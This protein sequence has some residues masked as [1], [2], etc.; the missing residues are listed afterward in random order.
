G[1]LEKLV[2]SLGRALPARDVRLPRSLIHG[3]FKIAQLLVR[4]G[5][6]GLVDFD[7]V[8]HGDPLYD[9]A[10]FVASYLYLTATH[11]LSTVAAAR[12][13]DRFL[14]RY[15][16]HTPWPCERE[17]IMWYVTAFLLGKLNASLKSLEW[18]GD[19]EVEPA[20][21]LIQTALAAACSGR[22]NT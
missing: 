10:E 22:G 17:R 18:S 9:V 12:G 2:E 16:E 14:A 1:M 8:A 11:D 19:D 6:L 5:K 20:L 7:S 21:T 15:E 3:T 13:I 4:D